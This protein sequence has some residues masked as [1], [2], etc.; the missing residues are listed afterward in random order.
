MQLIWPLQS[1]C[2]LHPVLKAWHAHSKS[3]ETRQDPQQYLLRY[4]K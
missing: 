4:S 2:I 1:P 3:P